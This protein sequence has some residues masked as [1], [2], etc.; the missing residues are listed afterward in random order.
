MLFVSRGA[1]DTLKANCLHFLLVDD[2][3]SFHSTSLEMEEPDISV[4]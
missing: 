1:S 3:F 2:W 4:H